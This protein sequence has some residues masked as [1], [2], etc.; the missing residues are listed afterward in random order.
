MEPAD[1]GDAGEGGVRLEVRD[2]GR[3]SEAPDGIGLSAMRERVE[4]LGGSLERRADGGTVITVTLPRRQPPADARETAG[5]K[6][7]PAALAPEGAR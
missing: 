4:G 2:D 1:V 7:S 5:A 6:P 3:G